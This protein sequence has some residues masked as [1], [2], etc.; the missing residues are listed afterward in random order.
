MAE[1]ATQLR[2]PTSLAELGLDHDSIPGVAKIIGASPV[3]NPR[4]YTEENVVGLME[5]AYL[6]TK[7]MPERN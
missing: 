3:S 4:D 1:L 5:Q 6:G 2:A 7:P